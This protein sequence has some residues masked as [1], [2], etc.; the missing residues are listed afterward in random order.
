MPKLCE[1]MT[2]PAPKL[3]E[4]GPAV[5]KQM[6]AGRGLL[7]SRKR[8]NGDPGIV[9]ETA[10]AP[11]VDEPGV[12]APKMDEPETESFRRL[13]GPTNNDDGEDGRLGWKKK[14]RPKK[15]NP[16][17]KFRCDVQKLKN[18]R[19][20]A[21]FNPVAK[22]EPPTNDDE[23]GLD[24]D[25]TENVPAPQVDEPVTAPEGDLTGIL[26]V[27]KP[28]VSAVVPE[29]AMPSDAETV[30][31]SVRFENGE[32]HKYTK[33]QCAEKFG[34]LEVTP[35]MT[36]HH[37]TRGAG[38]SAGG[39]FWHAC[40]HEVGR[41][42]YEWRNPYLLEGAVRGEVWSFGDYDRNVGPACNTWC[43]HCGSGRYRCLADKG[44]VSLCPAAS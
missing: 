44:A 30:V 10:P 43:R 17:G 34:V 6:S 15:T 4:T 21:I 22:I 5:E 33:A 42:F 40:E 24:W 3:L 20:A 29:T 39:D 32:T 19:E 8:D 12:P 25:E 23:G 14:V 31:W 35:G 37:A 28:N 13:D 27:P 26:P 36:V 18:E 38:T 41:S 9:P 1:P 7:W 2:T 16:F 11:K